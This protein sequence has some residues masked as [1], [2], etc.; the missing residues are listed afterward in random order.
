MHKISLLLSIILLSILGNTSISA[1]YKQAEYQKYPLQKIFP[2]QSFDSIAA[3]ISLAKGSSVIKGVA[4]TKPTNNLGFKAPLAEK[5]YANHITVEL[6]PYT[7]YF[8][9]WYELKK[10]KENIRKNKIVYMDSIAYEHR[11]YC[12]TNSRGEFTF[13]EIKPGKYIIMGTLPWTSSSYQ[14]TY[15]GSGYGSYGGRVDY[16]DRHY[17]TV[18]HSD[19]L[20]QVITVE[21]NQKVTKVKLK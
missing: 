9:E 2:Q 7:P 16:Y 4:F 17:Y 5:I 19:F 12:E 15:S 8:E 10:R 1:Q 11:L 13:P 14:D 6:F 18:S 3:R 21:P 20:I